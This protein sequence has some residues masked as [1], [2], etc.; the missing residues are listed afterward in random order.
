MQPISPPTLARTLNTRPPGRRLSREH[1]PLHIREF[2]HC[3]VHRPLG[4]RISMVR[5]MH[6]L[7]NLS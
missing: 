6:S 2:G 1:L 3:T 5:P 7:A 4:R